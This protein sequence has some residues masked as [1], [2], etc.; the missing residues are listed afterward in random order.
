MAW[1]IPPKPER[2]RK[3][4]ELL[5]ATL[6]ELAA[7][8]RPHLTRVECQVLAALQQERPRFTFELAGELGHGKGV[9]S[10]AISRLVTLGYATRARSPF[11]K[12][13]IE[14]RRTAEGERRLLPLLVD[15]EELE[16]A[17]RRTVALYPQ[18]ICHTLKILLEAARGFDFN[19]RGGRPR[20]PVAPEKPGR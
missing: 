3:V 13:R 16:G 19:R 10:K 11:H 5:E 17:L 14:V 4:R 15:E 2:V 20:K 9:V 1:R 18:S 6:G 7:S 8:E 12:K